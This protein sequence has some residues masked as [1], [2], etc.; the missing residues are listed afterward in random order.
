M[1]AL[2]TTGHGSTLAGSVTLMPFTDDE[3]RAIMATVAKNC[4]P[5]EFTMLMRLSFTYG[6]DPFAKEIWAIKRNEREPAMIMTSRDGYLK[7]AQRDQEFT[8]LKGSTV[9]ENDAFEFDPV[10]PAVTHRLGHPRGKIVGAWAMATH[11][12]RSPVAMY[13]DFNE[14]KGSSPIWTRFPSAMI[15][16]CFDD[17]TEVLTDKGFQRF[18]DVTGRVMQVTDAGLDP[19]DAI[20]F[21][22]A[23]AGDMV[24]LESDDLNFC[25]TPNHDMV[26]TAG[27][28]EAGAMYDAARARIIHR[29]P[30][31][32]AG[33]KAE[34]PYSDDMLQ[35]WAA[36]LADGHADSFNRF[37]ISVSR[38]RKIEALRSIGLH[39]AEYTMSAAGQQ[40]RTASRTITTRHDKQTFSYEKTQLGDLFNEDKNVALCA[41]LALSRRQAR[42]LV[43]AWLFFDGHKNKTGVRRFY[44]S[45]PDHL[46]AF[47]LAAVAAGYAV[48]KARERTSDISTRPG[49][50]ITVSGRDAIG[51]RR[52]GREYNNVDNGNQVGRTGLTLTPNASGV[53]WCVTV[54][55]GV[56]VV[57]RNGFS[58]LCGNCAEVLVL[59]RQV[60]ISGLVTYEEIDADNQAAQGEVSVAQA[61]MRSL[62]QEA[63]ER[64]QRIADAADAYGLTGADAFKLARDKYGATI[65]AADLTDEQ[66]DDL[67]KKWIPEMAHQRNEEGAADA[68]AGGDDGVI[69]T[70]AYEV[71]GPDAIDEEE[72]PV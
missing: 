53:V 17:Q 60:G 31:S 68:P 30:R 51:V 33:T 4:S 44:T 55:S 9:C 46:A 58:M 36:Y 20:P 14:Y 1:G 41:I 50:A 63:A 45:R 13:V 35:L 54:P 72:V 32:V 34:A 38:P 22:Q 15:L 62:E 6:L 28:I 52:W 57:R 11:A 18:A 24:T 43:D 29:I 47:E 7:I 25:V 48:N 67:V 56:I 19:T 61:A 65:T 49:F 40:A 37:R 70:T 3:R 39:A 42:V 5:A 26:T 16:K 10:T 27:K 8:G 12:R 59:K 66:V 69:D 71:E 23:Y 64:R 21:V 2:T